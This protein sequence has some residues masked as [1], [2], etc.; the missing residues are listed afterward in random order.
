MSCGLERLTI[1]NEMVQ[2]ALKI[3]DKNSNL[4]YEA[5]YYLATE[6]LRFNHVLT[7]KLLFWQLYCSHMNRL[8]DD[9]YELL[10][11]Y[12]IFSK[13]ICKLF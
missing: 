12:L 1:A 7:S 5:Q 3:V 11:K 6:E 10:E 2:V 4:K 9:E 8:M 13:F